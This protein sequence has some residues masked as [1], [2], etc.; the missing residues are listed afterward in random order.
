L[1]NAPF[2]TYGE[3]VIYRVIGASEA[4]KVGAVA[5]LVRSIAPF[6]LYTPHTGEQFYED[7]VPQIPV[8]AVTIEDSE[9]MAR[10]QT[11]GQT[12]IVQLYMEA[13]FGHPVTHYNILA[14]IKGRESPEE[15]IVIGGHS[16]SWDVGQ[17]AID[18]GGGLFTSWEA[19]RLISLLINRSLLP[20]PRRTIRVLH[21]VDE[22]IGQAGATTYAKNHAADIQNHV[23]AVE[24]DA[25]NFAP[26]GFGFSG[27]PEATKIITQIG[28]LL[29]S[30]GAGN[31]T[32]G[33]GE[34]T[35]NGYLGQM[36]V[37]CGSLESDGFGVDG[38]YFYYHHSNADTVTHINRNGFKSS[39]AAF[40]VLSYVVADMEQRLPFG[41]PSPPPPPDQRKKN[42]LKL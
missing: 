34:D 14:D 24:S 18:D 33:E 29:H 23:L 9:M 25:G 4:A 22:E 12:I 28:T 35:D 6:S 16:D 38:Y 30:I 42:K 1:Y 2:V 10:M 26:T 37:P 40:A 31:I 13:H 39:I 20:R 36:G 15:I 5:A 27:T 3:T 41:I 7:G 19:A 17:G 8:A 11:R 32:A 21:W